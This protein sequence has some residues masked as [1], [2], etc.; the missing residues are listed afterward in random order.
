MNT[1]IL[2]G[3]IMD[4]ID[5]FKQQIQEMMDTDYSSFIKALISIETGETK[6]DKLQA[7]SD[8]YM[9]HDDVTLV[10]QFFHKQ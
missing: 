8:S 6:I 3:Y 5:I 1:C 2:G 7:L 4:R 9:E 10:K